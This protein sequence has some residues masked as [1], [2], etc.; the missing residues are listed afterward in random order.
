M[1]GPRGREA[2][3]PSAQPGQPCCR[4]SRGLQE[5]RLHHERALHTESERGH[6]RGV[7]TPWDP[8][9]EKE[10]HRGRF[11]A[12]RADPSG[13]IPSGLRPH[14]QSTGD[15][16]KCCQTLFP[17]MYNKLFPNSQSGNFFSAR[18]FKL[19]QFRCQVFLENS[20]SPGKYT[21]P[22]PPVCSKPIFDAKAKK[23]LQV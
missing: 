2:K 19:S 12:E 14:E 22:L 4:G 13:S 18:S 10:R 6:D 7:P 17:G 23:T 1:C 3:G 15:R 21:V 5:R 8:M 11:E 9:C 20:N 16:P